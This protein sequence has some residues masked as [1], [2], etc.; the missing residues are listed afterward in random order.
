MATG[1]EEIEIPIKPTCTLREACEW[2]AFGYL[3]TDEEFKNVYRD[4]YPYQKK[5]FTGGERQ[6][7]SAD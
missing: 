5:A 2:V 6:I 3:P 4:A 1:F 7:E